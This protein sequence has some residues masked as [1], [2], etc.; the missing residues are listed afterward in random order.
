M[1]DK[2]I[3]AVRLLR[4]KSQEDGMK[5][6]KAKAVYSAVRDA[7]LSF[8][9]QNKEFADAV[10]QSDKTLGACCEKIMEKSGHAISDIE[11]Y[12]R[13]VEFYF[14]GA[15]IETKMTVYM[16][17]FERD[18]ARG[19]DVKSQAPLKVCDLRLEDFLDIGR[20]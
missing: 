3:E 12:A 5:S 9:E 11:V 2:Q 18:A 17:S 20:L 4:E 15:V 13:A 14:P 8:C 1:T 7:L 6:Q 19:G 16:S 10:L